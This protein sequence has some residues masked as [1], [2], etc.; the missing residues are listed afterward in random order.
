MAC[1]IGRTNRLFLTFWR[2]ADYLVTVVPRNHQRGCLQDWWQVFANLEAK[3]NK[4]LQELHTLLDLCVRG[5]LR[6]HLCLFS[7]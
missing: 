6:F 7:R 2:R 3:L 5:L 4:A 1:Q